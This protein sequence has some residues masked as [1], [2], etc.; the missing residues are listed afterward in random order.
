M[1]QSEGSDV[2]VNFIFSCMVG[3]SLTELLLH[4]FTHYAVMSYV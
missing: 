3:S 2:V 1:R 4:M